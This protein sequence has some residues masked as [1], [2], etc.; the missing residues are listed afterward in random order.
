MVGCGGLRLAI[1]KWLRSIGGVDALCHGNRS[2]IRYFEI[3]YDKVLYH[4]GPK[5]GIIFES[6]VRNDGITQMVM[7]EGYNT[8]K[9]CSDCGFIFKYNNG[10]Q[11]PEVGCPALQGEVVG[12]AKVK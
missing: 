8:G 10:K 12:E 7:G 3:F 4:I 1:R 9:I 11:P 6:D 2:S 5:G